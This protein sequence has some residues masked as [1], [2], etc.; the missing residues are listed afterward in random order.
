MG[1]IPYASIKHEIRKKAIKLLNLKIN[2]LFI[3]SKIF[4]CRTYLIIDYKLKNMKFPFHDF[5][6]ILEENF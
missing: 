3:N 4:F 6:N 1:G 5:S 2:D